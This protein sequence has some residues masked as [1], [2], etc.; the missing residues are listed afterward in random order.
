MVVQKFVDFRG[1]E[2]KEVAKLNRRDGRVRLEDGENIFQSHSVL[3]GPTFSRPHWIVC[4]MVDGKDLSVQYGTCASGGSL[5]LLYDSVK[6]G[7][8]I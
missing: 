7:T 2:L 5:W 3:Y 8:T 4:S 1:L 6:C